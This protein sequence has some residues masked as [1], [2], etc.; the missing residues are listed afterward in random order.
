MSEPL[1]ATG[2]ATTHW[3]WTL[4]LPPGWVHLPTGVAEGRRAVTALLDRRLRH[5]P[6]DEIARGRRV[7]ERELR[8]ALSDARQAGAGD[9]WTQVDLVAGMPVTAGLLVARLQVAADDETLLDGLTRVLGAAGDVVESGPVLAGGLPA[10]RR[11]RRFSRAL[12]EGTSEL[13]QTG[14]DW[15]VPLPGSDDVPVLSFATSTWQVADELVQVFDAVAGTLELAL[16]EPGSPARAPLSPWRP[17]R[18]RGA[19]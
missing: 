3:D 4:L 18:G 11:R 13:P 2:P 1:R 16:T 14:V 5:L 12:A 6:R 9:V 17:P 8:A 7:L 19:G 15:P 10:L